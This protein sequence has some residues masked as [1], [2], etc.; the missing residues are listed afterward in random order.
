MQL[1]DGKEIRVGI[2]E[3]VKRINELAHDGIATQQIVGRDGVKIILLGHHK[4]MPVRAT[5]VAQAHA[6]NLPL[7]TPCVVGV[8][9]PPLSCLMKKLL[10]L[11]VDVDTLKG[12]REGVPRLL[13]LFK[14]HDVGATFLFSLGPDH[15]G[16][17]VRRVLRKG[18][19]AKVQRTSVVANY[20]FPTLLYGTL[21]PGPDIGK[22]G[23]D[24]MRRTDDEGFEVGIHCWD[25]VRWQDGVGGIE[26]Q[27]ASA[28]WTREEMERAQSRFTDIFKR[29]ARTHGAA[30]WQMNLHALRLTQSMG[31]EYCSDGRAAMGAGVPHYPVVRA[32]IINCPQLPTTLPTMD[33]LIG[34]DGVTEANVNESL[35]A[36][37]A[38]YAWTAETPLGFADP[39]HVFTLHAE[40]EGLRF[41][42]RLESLIVGWKEQGFELVSTE[43]IAERLAR[44]H[45]PYFNATSGE[46]PGRSGKLLLQ[47]TPWL[48]ETP[49][50][51][52]AEAA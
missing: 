19:F 4:I 52:M 34:L 27:A 49:L 46:I 29:P 35:L 41:L 25:H 15:T 2:H 48:A 47:G 11:K 32:E 39:P 33:E 38:S 37:T 17:A 13:A 7:A 42:D 8:S 14:K 18:F 3:V 21:L 22:R 23:A 36:L 16:R 28:S 50:A 1:A 44:A 43:R 30:G 40:L 20:G 45:L 24:I 9:V 10:A 12:T 6:Y 5:V 26:G 31:F 51:T